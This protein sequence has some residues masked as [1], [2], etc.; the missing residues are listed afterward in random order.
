MNHTEKHHTFFTKIPYD[1]IKV[2]SKY[3]S[4]YGNW[5]IFQISA[6]SLD[7]EHLFM[8]E[9]REKGTYFFPKSLVGAKAIQTVCTVDSL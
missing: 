8:F 7:A 3:F 5:Y 2:G 4:V 6:G 1:F 9:I